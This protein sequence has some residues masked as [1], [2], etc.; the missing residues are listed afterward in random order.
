[1]E[2]IDDA[3]TEELA[4]QGYR[5]LDYLGEGQTRVAYTAMFEEGPY[6]DV[7][8][9]KFPKPHDPVSVQT[10]INTYGRGVDANEVEQGCEFRHPNLVR[11]HPP[12]TLQGAHLNV[13]EYFEARSLEDIIAEEGLL[14]DQ[15]FLTVFEQVIAAISYL[16]EEKQ[17]LHRDIK[18]S[19]ILYNKKTGEVKLT[20]LQNTRPLDEITSKL[21]PT[22]GGI[23]SPLLLNGL[24]GH[25]PT[26]TTVGTELFSLGATM[27][28]AL[29]GKLPFSYRAIADGNGVLV[30][31]P[32]GSQPLLIQTQRGK[33][34]HITPRDH[35]RDLRRS[36]RALPKRWRFL[37]KLLTF[38]STYD[39]VSSF[40]GEYN[41]KKP[42]NFVSRRS[43]VTTVAGLGAAGLLG[44]YGFAK[45]LE[46]HAELEEMNRANEE[47]LLSAI[48]GGYRIGL[49]Y[50][51]DNP[52]VE[53]FPYYD[54]CIAEIG[55]TYHIPSDV[56]RNMILV[57]KYFGH[58]VF[59][60]SEIANGQN[61][62]YLDPIAINTKG[63]KTL[64]EPR[65]N[66]DWG[67]RRLANLVRQSGSV[68]SGVE[69]YYDLPET[70]WLYSRQ[71]LPEAFRDVDTLR[72]NIVY[73]V[74]VGPGVGYD[75][76]TFSIFLRDP[77]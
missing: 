30:D 10:E 61:I 48:K 70:N 57:N 72:K 44:T 23:A 31:L 74:L 4:A 14:D 13:E 60:A 40:Q 33:V 55:R 54:D 35:E 19:N 26:K 7:R 34:Q 38:E 16:A 64:C 27:Y 76:G 58:S 71:E 45:Y 43:F 5:V 56:L 37:E 11:L 2:P 47:Q 12:V 36:M 22:R 17:V 62:C 69:L 41:H 42:K 75:G 59:L 1:M 29:T 25:E 77:H 15:T 6:R 50:L 49:A 21:L 18:P 3:V 20:D 46:G 8:V 28:Y 52:G 51:V 24:L 67:A 68:A 73:N 39:S 63:N 32:S 66:L 9:I 65:I 53:Q